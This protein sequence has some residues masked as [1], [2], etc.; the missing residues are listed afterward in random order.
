M[1][2]AILMMVV[3]KSNSH[4]S[5]TPGRRTRKN[6]FSKLLESLRPNLPDLDM[7]RGGCVQAAVIWAEGWGLRCRIMAEIH[8]LEIMVEERRCERGASLLFIS[9]LAF[10]T[11]GS[12][13]AERK[14][15]LTQLAGCWWLPS[16]DNNGI[17]GECEQQCSLLSSDDVQ[18]DGLQPAD[19][20]ALAPSLAVT[21]PAN[22]EYRTHRAGA[23]RAAGPR[24]KH[25]KLLSSCD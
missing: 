13:C 11:D 5:Q 17:G 12:L 18:T 19:T 25:L 4:F 16:N 8:W 23:W 20:V 22:V 7:D 9:F 14:C 24:W 15:V 1:A 6:I 2:A 10:K 3:T 21:H